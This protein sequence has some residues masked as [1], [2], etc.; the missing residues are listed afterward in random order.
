MVKIIDLH[1]HTNVSDGKYSP[2][3]VVDIALKNGLKV[4]AIADHDTIDAYTDEL[5]DYATSNNLILVPAVEISTKINKCGIHVLGYNFDLK[6]ENFKNKLSSF[7]NIRHDY[8]HKVADKLETLGYKVNVIELDKVEA[9]TKA[10]ISLDVISN[11]DNEQ[12]LL[13]NFGHI[14]SKGEF[15]ETVM[16]EGCPAYV[17][18]E[19]VTP[20]EAANLIRSAGGKVVLAHPVAYKYEDGLTKE[21]ILSLVKEMEIDAIEGNY[22]YVDRNNKKIDECDYWNKFA[23]DNKLLSTIGSDFHNFDG[24][25]AE[26]GLINEDIEFSQEEVNK[27]LDYLSIGL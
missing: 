10:H 9:V 27:I 4:L 26:I 8:L 18:K 24:L 13:D 25:R 20:I 15:I 3:E 5:I 2:K 22:I 12:L 1:V 21:D 23:L 14:P 17:K 16:N 7:R 6:D 11:K 19:T